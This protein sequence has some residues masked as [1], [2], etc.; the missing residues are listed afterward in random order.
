MVLIK[1]DPQGITFKVYIQPRS[2][3]NMIVGPH[4]DAV[5]GANDALAEQRTLMQVEGLIEERDRGWYAM[6]PERPEAF[7]QDGQ[8]LPHVK[9]VYLPDNTKY[10]IEPY[11]YLFQDQL[12]TAWR[13]GKPDSYCALP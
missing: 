1:E 3:Q 9:K 2:S 6:T 5:K 8:Y 10:I 11:D 4:G 7:P 12:T 13:K